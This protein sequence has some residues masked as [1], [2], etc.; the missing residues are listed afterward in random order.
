MYTLN[1]TLLSVILLVTTKNTYKSDNLNTDGL[2]Q[3]TKRRY[4]YNKRFYNICIN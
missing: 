1:T 4:F 2:P 3:S